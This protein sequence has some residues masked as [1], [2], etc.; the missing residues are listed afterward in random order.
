MDAKRLAEIRERAERARKTVDE[1]CKG[2]AFTMSVPVDENND[3]DFILYASIDDTSDL[4]AYIG[5]LQGA[6]RALIADIKRISPLASAHNSKL[7]H[8]E[9]LFR[10]SGG[11]K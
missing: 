11:E 10:E 7:K 1:L 5:E 9:K 6:T 3:T 2:R 8:L 4:L